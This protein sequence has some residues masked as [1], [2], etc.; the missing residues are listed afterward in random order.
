MDA[1]T[2]T[3]PKGST[4]L[5]WFSLS[6]RRS[7][8]VL[9]M[10]KESAN[11]PD[12]RVL[13]KHR[14]GVLPDG[15]RPTT[16]SAADITFKS[17]TG[18]LRR[19]VQ[20]SRPP[21]APPIYQ[22]LPAKLN[23]TPFPHLPTISQAKRE[24]TDEDQPKEKPSN[25]IKKIRQQPAVT[26]L[27]DITHIL[28]SSAPEEA[29][30]QAGTYPITGMTESHGEKRRKDIQ[31]ERE[32]NEWLPIQGQKAHALQEKDNQAALKHQ[33]CEVELLRQLR[34]AQKDLRLSELRREEEKITLLKDLAAAKR[35]LE[36]ANQEAAR[37]RQEAAFSTAYLQT[38]FQERDAAETAKRESID[39]EASGA[40]R[41]HTVLKQMQVAEAEKQVII[42]QFQEK[43]ASLTRQL[44]MTLEENGRLEERVKF[45]QEQLKSE[46]QRNTQLENQLQLERSQKIGLEKLAAGPQKHKLQRRKTELTT[47]K[48]DVQN[49]VGCPVTARRVN[50][51]GAIMDEDLDKLT[52]AMLGQMKSVKDAFSKSFQI[53]GIEY[54]MNDR[55]YQQFDETRS[56]FKNLGRGSREV[57]LFHG[58]N[59]QNVNAYE[60][61]SVFLTLVS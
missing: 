16:A 50:T 43:E 18:S 36:L 55:L 61:E 48:R 21:T 37:C 38:V 4:P 46:R 23:T 3:K 27:N 24:A 2:N 14:F 1:A 57:L 12:E 15:N 56:K 44:K 31:A 6:K 39:R 5:R 32:H 20:L 54:I 19:P 45:E 17:S 34:A 60:P 59:Q 25:T 10:N 49:T 22:A 53:K 40:R 7:K 52:P 26:Q 58:T 11:S 29:C 30:L 47:K 28:N 8:S 35:S 51:W 42:Y 13:K 33:Q 41:L 9:S